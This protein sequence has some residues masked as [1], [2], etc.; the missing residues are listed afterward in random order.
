GRARYDKAYQNSK[1]TQAPSTTIAVPLPLG[2][3]LGK[4][5]PT[6]NTT[7]EKTLVVF[8]FSPLRM[9]RR[10]RFLFFAWLQC[11]KMPISAEDLLYMGIFKFNKIFM[12]KIA[13]SLTKLL[14]CGKILL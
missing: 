8:V 9:Q 10:E 2:G 4:L 3:R 7:K 14:I 11:I 12:K 1:V 6:K 5:S 13:F